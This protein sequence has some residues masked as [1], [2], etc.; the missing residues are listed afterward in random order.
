MAIEDPSSG[1]ADG[2]LRARASIPLGGGWTTSRSTYDWAG[3]LQRPS[4]SQTY[5]GM[6]TPSAA[7]RSR[8]VPSEESLDMCAPANFNGSVG[9]EL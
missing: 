3:V 9:A 8:P 6:M 2:R 1:M 4:N 5:S 7:P